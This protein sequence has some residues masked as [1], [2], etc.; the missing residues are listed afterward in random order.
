MKDQQDILKPLQD[1]ISMNRFNAELLDSSNL[2]SHKNQDYL[3][4]VDCTFEN[5]DIES[6]VNLNDRFEM[7]S[8]M[9]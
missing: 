8:N 2:I 1:E 5:S 3:D 4:Q 7:V 6:N 9:S